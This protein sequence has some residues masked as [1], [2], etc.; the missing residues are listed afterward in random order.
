MTMAYFEPDELKNLSDIDLL[1]KQLLLEEK[2]MFCNNNETKQA[3]N[4]INSFYNAEI[5][6]RESMG[7]LDM[8]ELEDELDKRYIEYQKSKKG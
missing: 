6:K 8:D 1:W 4:S 3:L 7:L 2:M 5:Q